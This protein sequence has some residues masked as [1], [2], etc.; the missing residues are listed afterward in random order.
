MRDAEP[1][2]DDYKSRYSW[3]SEFKRLQKEII[4]LWHACNVSLAHRSYFFLLF[5]GDST[6]AIYM[7]VEIRR[8]TSLKDA[9]SRGEKTVASGRTLS[10]E[11]W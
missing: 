4:E 11:G 10:F 2:E 8:L 7:E 9:F 6:D 5:Q 1:A 3:P